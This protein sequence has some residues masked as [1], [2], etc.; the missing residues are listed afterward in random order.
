MDYDDIQVIWNDQDAKTFY[1]FDPE[2]FEKRVIK[3]S[4]GIRQRFSFTELTLATIFAVTG[5]LSISEPLLENKDHIQYLT[6]GLYLLVATA[7]T[8][9]WRQRSSL[10]RFD[11][12]LLQIIDCM[13]GQVQSH[14]RFLRWSWL[15]LGTPYALVVGLSFAVQGAGKPGWLWL[16]ALAGLPASMWMTLR[17]IPRRHLPEIAELE[18]LRTTLSEANET[19]GTKS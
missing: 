6:G 5:V 14:V 1:G 9:H 4:E 18:A 15:W 8:I 11:G 7:V 12:S 2:A 17:D 19:N 13:I 3:K 16:L 10:P